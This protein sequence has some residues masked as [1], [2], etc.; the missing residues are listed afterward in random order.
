MIEHRERIRWSD[1]DSYGHVNNA[2][3]L[4]YL[5]EARD[6]WFQRVMGEA[7][8]FV[9]VRVAIDFRSEL[10]LD[11]EEVVV[12]CTGT[13]VGTSSVQTREEIRT[14][15]GRLAAEALSVSVKHDESARAS[16]PL[17]PEERA[18]LQAAI[19]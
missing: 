10:T 16:V 9:L 5:E 7:F 6:R 1:V 14:R 8:G 17:T 2:V 13:S 3:Y 12:S 4:N 18:T 19:G 15:D 11:D